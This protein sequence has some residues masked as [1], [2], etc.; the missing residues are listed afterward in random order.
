MLVSLSF[1]G[2]RNT[3]IQ[4]TRFWMA[5]TRLSLKIFS[6]FS[7]CS[8]RLLHN[9]SNSAWFWRPSRLVFSSNSSNPHLISSS[10]S[11]SAAPLLEHQINS[12]IQ[13]KKH[14]SSQ[15]ALVVKNPPANAR[16]VRDPGLIPGSGRSPGEGNGNPLLYSCLENPMDRGA[17]WAAVPGVT[18]NWTWLKRLSTHAHKHSQQTIISLLYK[19]KHLKFI[20]CWSQRAGFNPANSCWFVLHL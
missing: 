3:S 15:V 18:E 10:P 4:S 14:V 1:P 17:W 8:K 13:S 11:D 19:R 2:E 5:Y 16:D 7:S 9:I 6:P 12:K 20:I